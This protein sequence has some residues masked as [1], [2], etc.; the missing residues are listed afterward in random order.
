MRKNSILLLLAGTVVLALSGCQREKVV[1]PSPLY[2]P[3]TKEV[4]AEFVL[5]VAA[6]G[7]DAK[8]KMSA[9][10]VQKANNFRGIDDVH[11]FAY[12]TNTNT[13]NGDIP[14]VTTS[15][16]W[17]DN[18]VKEFQ[19]GVVYRS[20]NINNE[21]YTDDN[22]TP[23]DDTDDVIKNNNEQ[24]SSRRVLQLSI[25]VGTDAVLFYGTATGSGENPSISESKQYGRSVAS[26][27][28]N[29]KDTEIQVYRRIGN[30]TDES[31]YN[32][33]GALMI[34]VINHIVGSEVAAA[35]E[36]DGFT[37]LP[38]LSWKDLGARYECYNELYNNR[39]GL[40]SAEQLDPLE[41]ILGKTYSSFTYIKPGEYR[42]GASKAIKFMIENIYS[43]INP[44]ATAIPTEENEANAKRLA[45]EIKAR[46]Q[47][48]FNSSW[49][50]KDIK[51]SKASTIFSTVVDELNLMSED[52]W[53]AQFA[54]A[55]DLN[56]YPYEDFNIPEG[57]AQLEFNAE[58]GKFNYMN[59]NKPLV[60]Q[61][62]TSFKPTKYVY[63]P[64]LYYYV[65]SPIR[66]NNEQWDSSDPDQATFYPNGSSPWSQDANWGAN[67]TKNGKVTSSTRSIAVCDNINYGVA[68]LKSSI[69]VPSTSFLDNRYV[70]SGEK[71]AD[72][73]I[74]PDDISLVG[75]LVG[76]VNP[77]YN[78]QFLRKY[79]YDTTSDKGMDFSKFDGVIY[80][81]AIVSSTIP[82]PA[83]KE[84]YTLVYDNYD[85][86]LDA[87]EQSNVYIALEFENNSTKDFFGRDNIIPSGSK[88][89]LVALLKN[90]VARQASITWPSD[91]QVPPVYGVDGEEG[92]PDGKKAGMSKEVPRIFIQDFMTTAVFT[93]SEGALKNAYYTMPD[94]RTANMSL[95][96]SV[97]L[98]WETG[99]VFNDLVF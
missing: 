35:G 40:E 48:F 63:A 85:S 66:V 37:G 26:F 81:D 99:Y 46:M 5:N 1:E 67:W 94:L 68:L 90:T 39:F 6:A 30:A 60:N 59:P 65:N 31:N 80:D 36:Q 42:A 24:N 64:E 41:E 25:P 70:L 69:A 89:Y 9:E 19:L 38:K 96:L 53:D 76:G 15:T 73:T 88:F 95:G 17:S 97:D 58:T 43:V 54:G 3:D 28:K 71:E 21:N 32:A 27:K 16:G 75:I 62:A 98:Q 83:G 50:Y 34:Y 84:N 13:S 44:V 93:M 2:N 49:N 77:R 22:G 10:T 87:D 18:N 11:I 20:S 79:D 12:S 29:P 72:Q 56:K 8:T 23:D 33:T 52:E 78:W 51:D 45:L 7:Q 86:S 91:H 92:L 82:T 57:A 61:L 14:Y 74:S 47:H 4:T 55:K